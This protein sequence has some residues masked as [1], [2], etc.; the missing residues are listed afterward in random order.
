MNSDKVP[1]PA[2]GGR[3]KPGDRGNLQKH[4]GRPGPRGN[5]AKGQRGQPRQPRREE[6]RRPVSDKMCVLCGKQIFDL[7]G[8]IADKNTGEPIHFDC[9]IESIA[10]AEPLAENE[11]LAYLGAGCF[12]VI[13]YISGQDGA[14]IVKRRIRWE[15]EGERQSWRREISSNIARI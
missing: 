8:A 11:K 1:N 13:S 2:G 3:R 5:F 14:F 6:P 15:K 9:A 10:A 7:V 4:G 12:G